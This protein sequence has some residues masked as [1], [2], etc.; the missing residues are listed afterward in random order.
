MISQPWTGGHQKVVD[1]ESGRVSLVLTDREIQWG[2]AGLSL[3]HQ[4]IRCLAE[5]LRSS[6]IPARTRGTGYFAV[7]S[8]PALASTEIVE[9][10][11]PVRRH[12]I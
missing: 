4:V 3:C 7:Q 11:Q 9:A 8:K 12:Q 10:P 1:G 6:G 5:F 2:S